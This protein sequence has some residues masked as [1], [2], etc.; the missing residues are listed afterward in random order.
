MNIVDMTNIYKP[1]KGTDLELLPCPFCGGDEVVYMEYEHPVGRR[2][3]VVCMG[4]MAEVDPGWA[5]QKCHVQDSWNRRA[6][7]KKESF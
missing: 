5:Q 4:C 7:N 3:A 2:W 1:A 6:G